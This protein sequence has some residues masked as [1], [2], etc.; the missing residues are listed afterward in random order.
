MI[1]KTIC[2]KPDEDHQGF[3]RIGA[4]PSIEIGEFVTIGRDETNILILTDVTVSGRHARIDRTVAGYCL[5][6]LQSR[7]GTWLNGLRVIEALVTDGDRIRVGETEIVFSLTLDLPQKM[8]LSSL[9]CV[10]NEQ[11]LRL[12]SIASSDLSILLL[13][14]SGSGKEVLAQEIHRLSNRSENSFVGVNCSALTESLVESELFGHVKGSFTGA[15]NDRKGAFESA[16]GW[17]LFLDE[18]GDLPLELQPKLLRA[19]ENRQIRPVGSDRTIETDVRIVAATHQNLRQKVSEGSFRADLYFR[20]NVVQIEVPPLCDRMEDF[21]TLVYYFARQYRVAFSHDAI[22]SLR[23]HTWPGNIR[24]LKNCIARAK[25]YFPGRQVETKDLCA[26]IEL[27]KN[28]DG[29]SPL[30]KPSRSLIREIEN[31]MI[32][33]R[34]LANGGNQRRTAVDLG[35]PK[36]T[37]H[38]RI[39]TYG[40]NIEKLL[41]EAGI[42][43]PRLV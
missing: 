40:I 6:D 42:K 13:G 22:Q 31:E 19:L 41:E 27:P 7:N 9:N 15:A 17:T 39:R 26:L 10:W 21:E 12:E 38:D 14:P 37:L 25:A 16:R 33:A 2:A 34:L 28:E 3:L 29:T 20:L 30:A 43:K 18:I 32:R 11:L 36:S 8:G 24:E 23:R 35:I 4:K 1:T 5:R